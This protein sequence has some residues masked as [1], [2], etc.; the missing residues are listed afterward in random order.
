[1]IDQDYIRHI[2]TYDPETGEF[3]RIKKKYGYH[4]N[5]GRRDS[6]QG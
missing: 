3:V 4:E 6:W 5:H 1:M 2:A